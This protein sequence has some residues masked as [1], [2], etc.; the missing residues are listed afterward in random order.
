MIG[1][2]LMG[3]SLSAG[4]LLFSQG[5]RLGVSRSPPP[6]YPMDR[7]QPLWVYLAMSGA[8]PCPVGRGV[9]AAFGYYTAC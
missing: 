5:M 9:G 7:T 2:L 3:L 6:S 8:R 4:Y 1:V